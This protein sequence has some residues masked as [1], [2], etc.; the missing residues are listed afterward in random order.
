[1]L[2]HDSPDHGPH[3]PSLFCARA[4]KQC[5]WLRP[6]PWLREPESATFPPGLSSTAEMLRP[7]LLPGIDQFCVTVLTPPL[8]DTDGAAGGAYA[9][10]DAVAEPPSAV[11]PATV[12]I[13]VS[14][15]LTVEP[16]TKAACVT[17]WPEV[18]IPDVFPAVQR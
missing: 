17:L 5:D 6:L 2:A 16:L 18:T 7:L 8:D 13:A 15:T 12:L 3:S 4:R 11:S 14:L 1:M 9:L 10:T